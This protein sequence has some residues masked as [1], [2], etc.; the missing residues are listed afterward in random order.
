MRS[1]AIDIFIIVL[2]L[3]YTL[4]VIVY[5]AIEDVIED[6]RAV[7]LS[8]QITEL[9][10][11]FIFCVEISL[12]LIGF[13]MFF[14]KDWWNI[15]DVTVILLAIIFVILDMTLDDSSLS[16]LFRLRGLF[17]LLR[18]GILIRKFDSIR[19]KSQARKRM[20]IRDIYHVSSPA[21]IVNEIL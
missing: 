19:K 21:E 3:L 4:L 9:V 6:H 11:L 8:L 10:F 14:I 7:E 12:N 13:G 5:L 20:Q 1:K 2:I 18:V 17:R 15:A 16:G